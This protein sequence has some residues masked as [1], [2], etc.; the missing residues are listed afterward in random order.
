M[1]C[2]MGSAFHTMSSRVWMTCAGRVG[3]CRQ[4]GKAV[5]WPTMAPHTW[6]AP[7]FARAGGKRTAFPPA[8]A[9]CATQKRLGRRRHGC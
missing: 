9:L 5:S 3:A 2:R 1:T 8:R 4:R 6:L 7:V